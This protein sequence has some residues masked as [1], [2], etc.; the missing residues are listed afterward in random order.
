MKQS[1]E[2]CVYLDVTHIEGYRSRE[3]FPNIYKT[4]LDFGFDMSKEPIPVVPAA[5]YM[6]GGVVVDINGQTNLSGLLASGEVC[7]SGLHGANRLA[8]N[9]LLEGLALSHRGVDKA[10]SLLNRSGSLEKYQNRIPKWGQ[11]QCRG[12]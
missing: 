2:D 7:C 10:A 5:H 6:C 8:S 12:Q 4:C 3:R 11:R 9:S 1:G